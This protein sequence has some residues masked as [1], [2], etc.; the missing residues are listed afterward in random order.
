MS[1]LRVIYEDG[2]ARP[3]IALIMIV[4]LSL[5]L[6]GFATLAF[7]RAR[8]RIKIAAEEAA[9]LADPN[10]QLQEGEIVLSGIVEHAPEHDVGVRVEIIQDGTE[11][12]SSG[13]YSHRWTEVE[14]TTKVAPFYLV[15]P[16]KTRVRVEPP[17]NVEVADNLDQKVLISDTR[18]IR[19]AELVPG[20][21]LHAHGWLERGGEAQ[22]TA[23][24][25][26]VAWGWLLRPANK[27]MMLSSYPLGDGLRKRARFHRRYGIYAV[28]GFLIFHATLVGFHARMAGTVSEAIVLD[29]TV[30]EWEDSD[31]DLQHNYRLDLAV[32][33]PSELQPHAVLVDDDDFDDTFKGQHLPIRGSTNGWSLGTRPTVSNIRLVISLLLVIGLL[34]TYRFRRVASRPWFRRKVVDKASGHLTNETESKE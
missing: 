8:R 27:R 2:A 4:G 34:V 21:S 13:S 19:R 7:M 24:Y 14:R 25:R 9:S 29:R 20:E 5:T 1:R 32:P 16:D 18:R 28:I 11:H 15:L 31:G 10:A 23:G 17:Q 26:D 22:A 30:E 6:L 33:G 12:E 3:T